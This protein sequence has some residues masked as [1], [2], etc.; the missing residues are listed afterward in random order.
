MTVEEAMAL[1]DEVAQP[2]FLERYGEMKRKLAVYENEF[3]SGAKHEEQ[4][5]P[6]T[7]EINEVAQRDIP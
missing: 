6:S 2:D 3:N 1:A 4:Q 5:R 7:R